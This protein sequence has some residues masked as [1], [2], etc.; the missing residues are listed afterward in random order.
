MTLFS[1]FWVQ[2][3]KPLGGEKRRG[4]KGVKGEREGRG[5]KG[6]L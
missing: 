3:S 2:F 4:R 1:S 6:G 5:K